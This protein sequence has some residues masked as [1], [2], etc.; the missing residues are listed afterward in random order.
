MNASQI[1]SVVIPALPTTVTQ[2]DIV[3]AFAPTA[4]A[5]PVDAV[6]VP[7]LPVAR[8]VDDGFAIVGHSRENNTALA[9]FGVTMG[10]VE[11]LEHRTAGLKA[12][13]NLWLKE[14]VAGLSSTMEASVMEGELLRHEVVGLCR[15]ALMKHPQFGGRLAALELTDG[16]DGIV[17]DLSLLQD[18][19]SD[20]KNVFVHSEIDVAVVTQ[21]L[22]TCL[23]T[24]ENGCKDY[25][26]TPA[27]IQLLD[28]RNRMY[29]LAIDSAFGIT[30]G[31]WAAFG[32]HRTMSSHKAQWAAYAC[33]G[34]YGWSL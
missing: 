25:V 22:N 23:Q 12:I 5:L 10:H 17:A 24:L 27:M 28:L 9:S 15:A 3:Q 1:K 20:A 19:M 16:I 34:E 14:R 8:F 33:M 21:K 7:F 13:H 32:I 4:Y 6:R 29:T 31:A 26:I 11:V 18:L 2:L 30:D